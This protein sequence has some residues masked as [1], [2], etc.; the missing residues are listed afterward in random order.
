MKKILVFLYVVALASGSLEHNIP[1]TDV[2]ASN[3][4]LRSWRASGGSLT[5]LPQALKS[6]WDHMSP[7]EREVLV[8]KATSACRIV[9]RC[10]QLASANGRCALFSDSIMFILE[11]VQV[12]THYRP[13]KTIWQQA[14][15][16]AQTFCTAFS[17]F[18][19]EPILPEEYF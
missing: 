17:E 15:T 1:S 7:S 18:L 11:Y 8:R 5:E 9:H 6:S 2:Q 16:D 10:Y 14:H 3:A 19:T 13:N 12:H 4:S